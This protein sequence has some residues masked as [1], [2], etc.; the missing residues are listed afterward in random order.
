MT[1][2]PEHFLLDLL[3]DMPKRCQA[4]FDANGMHIKY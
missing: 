1:P 4:V 2:A 3:K